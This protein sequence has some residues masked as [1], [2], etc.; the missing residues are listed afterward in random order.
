VAVDV[1]HISATLLGARGDEV[2][3]AAQISP[4]AL[5]LALQTCCL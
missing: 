5:G 3:S 4:L 2:L 1:K